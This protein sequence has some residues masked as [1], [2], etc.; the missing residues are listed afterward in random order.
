[1][2]P[3]EHLPIELLS[4]HLDGEAAPEERARA[5]AHLAAC[6]AC[7]ATF[8][9]FRTIAQASTRIEIP[10]IPEGLRER[11]MAAVAPPAPPR[12]AWIGAAASVAAAG[13]VAT[14]WYLQ[15]PEAPAPR[16]VA[17]ELEAPTP[18]APRV[19]AIPPPPRSEDAVEG[20]NDAGGSGTAAPPIPAPLRK[21]KAVPPPATAKVLEP[22][23]QADRE[24]TPGAEIRE[25]LRDTYVRDEPAPAGAVAPPAS[26]GVAD[27]PAP[28]LEIVEVEAGA[29]IDRAALLGA[30]AEAGLPAVTWADGRTIELV[31]PRTRWED[32]RVV[33]DRFGIRP[34][35]SK[36]RA[37]TGEAITFRIRTPAP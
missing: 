22:E 27:G 24:A 11:V 30:L 15:G 16:P 18:L 32:C 34:D 36:V 37:A 1:M 33:L 3:S 14:A 19:E 7:R 9:D 23:A 17:T 6:A 12:R 35:A 29:P 25:R 13:L 10:E 26:L 20:E 8:E 5:D 4:A 21:A 31:V 2:N 28:A